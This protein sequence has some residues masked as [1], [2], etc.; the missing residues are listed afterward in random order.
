MAFLYFSHART[1]VA[2]F[3]TEVQRL[4]GD[5]TTVHRKSFVNNYFQS[6]RF[7]LRLQHVHGKILGQDIR[8][9]PEKLRENK[10]NC[11]IDNFTS[12]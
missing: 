5:A 9:L 8:I 7:P 11:R 6:E 10:D 3:S 2:I 4:Q 12:L 1:Y